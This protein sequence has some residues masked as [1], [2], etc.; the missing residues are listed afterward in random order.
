MKENKAWNSEDHELQV[1]KN[2]TNLILLPL[3]DMVQA[4]VEHKHA[5]A[6]IFE[7]KNA[8]WSAGL[9]GMQATEFTAYSVF[10]QGSLSSI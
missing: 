1:A 8:I 2:I 9:L 10:M 7:D 5:P 3:I 6:V 4:G